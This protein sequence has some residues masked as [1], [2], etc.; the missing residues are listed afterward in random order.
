MKNK[1]KLILLIAI[2]VISNIGTYFFTVN[3]M[4]SFGH[5][6]VFSTGDEEVADHVSKLLELEKI[7]QSDYYKDVDEATVMDGAIK[8]MFDAIG[9]KYSA[10]Y[11]KDEFKS[12]M[13]T[14]TGT[15]EGIGI[16]VTEDDDKNTVVVTP[17]KG[18]PAGDAGIQTGDVIIKVDGEDVTGKGSD[19]AVSKMRGDAGTKVNVTVKR[20]DQEISYD[21]ERQSIDEQTVSSSVINDNVG[22]IS[23][24]EF[25]Q[26]TG[27]DFNSQLNDLQAK[28]I[29]SLVIDLRYNGGGL[30]DSAVS[31]ADRL[32]GDTEVVYTVKK[33]GE[34]QDYKSSGDVKFD[35]PIVVLVN[36]GTASASEIL[37]GAIQD[38]GAGTL[39]G[40]KTFGKGI[41]QEVKS[42]SDG[43][44]YKLTTAEYFTP[45]GRNIHGIGLTPNTVI[46]Q[47]P[48]YKNT[49]SVP[50]DQDTQLQKA[51]EIVSK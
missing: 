40:T 19:Y 33:D 24:S 17:Y 34:R 48:D 4:L 20:N 26:K 25:T 16:V 3:G 9:D 27:D 28:G 41:V 46:D 11:T 42:L 49:L 44:G 22:Y 39:V 8:G 43:S 5:H 38:T 10:Y 23:I 21:L 36:E 50:Q 15:Y 18:T 45:N 31:V 47:N 37:A 35:K 6:Y 32:L 1:K 12:L 13:E 7:I 2:I 29:T 51:L 30:V 14:S